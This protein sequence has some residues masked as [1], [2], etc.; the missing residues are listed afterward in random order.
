MSELTRKMG[1]ISLVFSG[2]GAF[3]AMAWAGHEPSAVEPVSKPT[4]HVP[5]KPASDASPKPL[6][7]P[8][9]KVAK[10]PA[11]TASIPSTS[12]HSAASKAD[13]P[14]PAIF[15]SA[16]VSRASNIVYVRHARAESVYTTYDIYSPTQP[17]RQLWPV[18]VYV[19][20]GFWRGGSKEGVG[21]KPAWF[22]D[23]GFLFVSV[24]YRLSIAKPGDSARFAHNVKHP[25]HAQDIALALADL[26]KRLAGYGG[27][28]SAVFLIG[29]SAGGHLASLVA[30]NPR[31][32]NDV[33][34][35]REN[36]RGVIAL[37]P[38]V[39][40]LPWAY[41]H[42]SPQIQAGY[43]NAFGNNAAHNLDASPLAHVAPNRRYPPFML[44]HVRDY[45]YNQGRTLADHLQVAR[46]HAT[47][48]FEPNKNHGT[49][50]TD[51]A[52]PDD[53]LGVALAE[54]VTTW[55]AGQLSGWT[56]RLRGTP[57]T[58]DRSAGVST[59]TQMR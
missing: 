1:L 46:S 21:H 47:L 57:Q 23:K 35:A 3:A 49:L 26:R 20:G 36:L 31:F 22:V 34:F 12:S 27:D 58:D 50:D 17:Q 14:K 10:K 32:L 9:P 2:F 25:S 43:R 51:F 24:N 30:L 16:L 55:M 13:W 44:V 45:S 18:V 8:K 4:I 39:I 6:A 19:H 29:H 40:D 53:T 37:D 54:Q 38:G 7:S 5:A 56:P 15:D 42:A 11:A 33:A 59:R 41:A 48:L 28:S 52:R